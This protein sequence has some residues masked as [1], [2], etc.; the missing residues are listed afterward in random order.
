MVL[1]LARP[2]SPG[3]GERPDRLLAFLDVGGVPTSIVLK[4]DG[5]EAF[6]TNFGGN[7]I[8]EVATGPSSTRPTRSW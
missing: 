5:G 8:S 1:G 6:T 7:S 3:V 2:A 4:P